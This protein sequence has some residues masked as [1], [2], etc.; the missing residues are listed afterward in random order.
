[1]ACTPSRRRP[2]SF[3]SISTTATALCLPLFA[4][5]PT[6]QFRIR[7]VLLCTALVAL[8][9]CA[10]VSHS[11]SIA[12][13]QQREEKIEY[14]L[15]EIYPDLTSKLIEDFAGG[16]TQKDEFEGFRQSYPHGEYNVAYFGSGHPFASVG[17]G[18]SGSYGGVFGGPTILRRNIC[19]DMIN[20]NTDFA[21]LKHFTA[22]SKDRIVD[23]TVEHRV[24]WY[25]IAGRCRTTIYVNDAPKNAIFLTVFENSL[26][27]T[28][29]DFEPMQITKD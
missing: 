3:T 15:L 13:A 10:Y 26:R 6:L 29:I 28:E 8:F 1:M 19:L 9:V 25:F 24:P 11:R 2:T 16:V 22:A 4:R 20:P 7:T 23:I 14:V 21:G 17:N 12:E 5:N 18:V 27:S